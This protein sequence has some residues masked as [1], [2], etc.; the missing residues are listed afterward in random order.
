MHAGVRDGV[1][2]RFSLQWRPAASVSVYDS[3][4]LCGDGLWE[5][6]TLHRGCLL[7]VWVSCPWSS[8]A[9]MLCMYASHAA[10]VSSHETRAEVLGSPRTPQPTPQVL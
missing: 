7:F 9:C 5:Q 1:T 2:K 3:G 8:V 10:S 4:F 6:F